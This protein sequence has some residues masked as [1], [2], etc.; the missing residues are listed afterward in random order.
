MTDQTPDSTERDRKFC[1]GC[2]RPDVVVGLDSVLYETQPT[3]RAHACGVGGPG[4]G[5]I[6]P[7]MVQM[8]L[9]TDVVAQRCPTCIHPEGY[10]RL[11]GPCPTCN[12]TGFDPII[13]PGSTGD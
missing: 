2:G 1:P 3:F 9:C 13:R 12:G 6:E 5:E 8:L 11:S 7:E 4:S 10:D